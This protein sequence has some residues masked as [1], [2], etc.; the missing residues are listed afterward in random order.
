[1]VMREAGLVLAF[2]IVGGLAAAWWLGRVVNNLLYGVQPS[3][4]ASIGVAVG[5]LA[6][7][8]TLDAW[9]PA[10]RASHIDPIQA[11]RYE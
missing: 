11:L 2:G 6:A 5:V 7:A 10:R 8:V 3:D 1:M 9:I 4:L